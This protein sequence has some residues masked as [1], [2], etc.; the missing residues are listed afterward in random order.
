MNFSAELS[1]N[2]IFKEISYSAKNLG[3]KAFVIGGYVRD[4][5]LNLSSKDI[6]IV[7][8]GSG[9]ELAREVANRL[10]GV[11]VT[12]FKSFG[13]AMIRLPDFELEFVAMTL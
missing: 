5:Q 7:C 10:G 11:P 3:V 4:L 12:V 2:P 6:D 9:I 13:T 1:Q 8:L